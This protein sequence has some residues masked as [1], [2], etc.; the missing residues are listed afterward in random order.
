MGGENSDST[1]DK[2][3]GTGERSPFAFFQWPFDKEPLLGPDER[4]RC[5]VYS[6]GAVNPTSTPFTSWKIMTCAV[7][8]PSLDGNEAKWGDSPRLQFSQLHLGEDEKQNL[9]LPLLRNG[10]GIRAPLT[11]TVEYLRLKLFTSDPESPRH[12]VICSFW[13]CE[14]EFQV[15]GGLG[16]G[17][18]FHS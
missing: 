7:G 3:K 16:H 18:W 11:V 8:S 10:V 14:L 17:I 4:F 15:V 1:Q 13:S 6:H 9:E 2:L 12:R 5:V